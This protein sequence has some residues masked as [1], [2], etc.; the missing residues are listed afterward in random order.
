MIA[1]SV[2]PFI[3]S[4]SLNTSS[5]MSAVGMIMA[6]LTARVLARFGRFLPKCCNLGIVL[7][8]D[9]SSMSRRDRESSLLGVLSRNDSGILRKDINNKTIY[10]IFF[11]KTMNSIHNECIHENKIYFKFTRLFT[12]TFI[13]K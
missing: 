13:H 12:R 7:S 6:R 5:K 4:L 11:K 2:L 3:L 8:R 1:L 10:Q 9:G